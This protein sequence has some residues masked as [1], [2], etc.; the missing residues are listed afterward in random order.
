[1]YTHTLK[2]EKDPRLYLFR[3]ARTRNA[4]CLRSNAIKF[5]EF[6][7]HFPTALVIVNIEV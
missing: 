4:P 3:V 1:M 6:F 5:R 2:F 7:L